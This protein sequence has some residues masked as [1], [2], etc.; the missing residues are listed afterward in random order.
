M[1]KTIVTALALLA[2]TAVASAT[3]LPSKTKAPLGPLPTFAQSTEYYVGGNLGGNLDQASVYSGGAV[4]GWNSQFLAVESTY[5]YT[6]PDKKISGKMDTKNTIAVNALP[7]YSVYGTPFTVYGLAGIGY[8]WNAVSADHSIYNV[9]GGVK[10]SFAKNIDIDARYRRIDAIEKK[11]RSE[12]DR[13]TLGVNY[14]F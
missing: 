1:Q 6:R 11:Y 2:S 4:A 3:D 14:K 13:A 8:T 7:Q 10:Y 9:G 12:E 5:D